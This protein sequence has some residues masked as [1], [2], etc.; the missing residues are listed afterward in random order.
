MDTRSSIKR[1]LL[2]GAI[3][4]VLE[5]YDFALYGYFAPIFA[6]L[7]FPSEHPSLSLITAFGVFAIG[8]LARPLG[9]ILFGYWGDTIGRRNAL[10]WSV[11]LMAIPTCLVG[12][13]PTYEM[14]GVA[15]PM[16]LTLCRFLQGLSVG[17]EFTGSVTF[18]VEHAAQSQRGYVGSWAGFSAQVGA[19]LGSGVGALTAVTLTTD[20]LHQWGWRIPFLLGG[21]IAVVGWYLRTK[22][23]ESPAFERLRQTGAL[24]TSPLRDVIAD[25][26]PPLIQLIGLVW[27]HGVA[28][29]LLYV[30]LTTY[31]VTVTTASL[32][33]V[34]TLNTGC[35]TLLALLIPVA[36]RLS[37]TVGQKPLLIIGA[38]GLVIFSYPLFLWL[39][40]GDL[41]YM[42]TGHILL[43]VLISC[44]MGPF[45]AA[46]AELFP[47][48]QR[49]TGLSLGYNIASALFG[50]TA[51]LVA[52]LLIEWSGNIHAPSLYL[53][54]CAAVSLVVVVT[55]RT[56][57][58][59][60]QALA[61][62]VTRHDDGS[63]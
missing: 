22:A 34:L 23:K 24:S 9:A 52:A 8:F 37:D 15:A 41:P 63:E 61:L 53:S 62:P 12:V 21:L 56:G 4:N 5:W 39:T 11:L 13:L 28:F 30:Y 1:T 54:F 26:R 43:T 16:V 25:H 17:G 10:A 58:R 27:L 32:G 40:S 51:P 14:I 48:R 42:I 44:Y 60:T 3:G 6:V 20:A 36:G 55:L 18:L 31:L 7:F 38:G 59:S 29:Y 33:T 35:M 50:G 49:Y 45:F 19:L 57:W 47:P 2:A 46:I